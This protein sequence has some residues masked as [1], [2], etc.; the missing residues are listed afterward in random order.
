VLG[1]VIGDQAAAYAFSA[2]KERP[3]LNDR[4]SERDIV[5]FWQ[6]GAVS[7]LD[8]GDI[9]SSKDVGMALMYDRRLPSGQSL[10]FR[11]DAG[12]FVDEETESVWNIWGEATDG[13]L[14]GSRL[15]QLHAYPHFWFAWAA[16]YPE[17]ILYSIE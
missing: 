1:A 4:I 9:D 13:P 12:R 14:A 16:F 11:H 3:V 7:A 5:I 6:P 10:S 15:R 8:A 17:T 2:L